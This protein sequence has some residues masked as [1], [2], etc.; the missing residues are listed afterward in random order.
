MS[1]LK[2]LAQAAAVILLLELM[3]VLLIFLG[4]SGGLAWGLRWSRG[5]AAI[6]IARVNAE[7]PKVSEYTE[8]ATDV[9][10][11]PFIKVAGVV[12]NVKATRDAIQRIVRWGRASNTQT[13]QVVA[14]RPVPRP[15]TSPDE[16]KTETIEPVS[17]V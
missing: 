2:H 17:L 16:E 15:I 10:A 11:A 5:K 12:E 1:V 9:A 3:V 4:I 13:T 6:G 7:L 14:A 8:R